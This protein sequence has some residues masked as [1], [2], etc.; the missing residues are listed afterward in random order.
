MS[1]IGDIIPA[2]DP[3]TSHRLDHVRPDD[4]GAERQITERVDHCRGGMTRAARR[5][6]RSPDLVDDAVQYA[7]CQLYHRLQRSCP[8]DDPRAWLN[9]V[10]YLH[11]KRLRRILRRAP[12]LQLNDHETRVQVLPVH[13]QPAAVAELAE[14]EGRV[15]RA[16]RDLRPR[17]RRTLQLR[18]AGL[19][20]A[21]IALQLGIS[22]RT[23]K[24]DLHGARE[25]LSRD[26]E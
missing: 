23:V 15:A 13:E 25:R 1:P 24:A 26:I 6:L 4:P 18:M 12:A 17:I 19:P 20:V 9:R 7:V 10:A 21:Q 16:I 11:S 2:Q 14:L 5:V 3:H 8:P 22:V